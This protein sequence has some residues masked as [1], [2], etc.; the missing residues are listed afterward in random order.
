MITSADS[1]IRVVN[2][3]EFVHRRRKGRKES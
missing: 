2:G 1:R 3:D